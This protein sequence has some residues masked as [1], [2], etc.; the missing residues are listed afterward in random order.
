MPFGLASMTLAKS[1]AYSV[2]KAIPADVCPEYKRLYGLSSEATLTLPAAMRRQE[3]KAKQAEF[4]ANIARRI[5]AIRDAN[6]GRTRSLRER[7]IGF[8]WRMVSLVRGSE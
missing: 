8:G 5:Q 7:R 3:A 1:G 2:R 4:L 6:A